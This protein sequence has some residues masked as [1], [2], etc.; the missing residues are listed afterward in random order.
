MKKN[1]IS[2]PISNKDFIETQIY[3]LFL[4]ELPRKHILKISFM[5]FQGLSNKLKILGDLGTIQGRI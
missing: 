5:E 1:A 4:S 3:G 2:E